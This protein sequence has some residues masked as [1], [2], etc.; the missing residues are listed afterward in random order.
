MKPAILLVAFGSASPSAWRVYAA[1]E[2]EVR[3]A[4]PGQTVQWAWTARS[5]VAR[6]RAQGETAQTMDEALATLA[7]GGFQS[8]AVL[9]LHLVPGEKHREILAASAP[10]LRL[11]YGRALLEEPEDLDEVA[12]DLAA[13]LP[14]DRPVLVVAHG[15]AHQ[16]RFNAELEALGARLAAIRPDLLLT[17]LEGE[18]APSALEAF[19]LRARSLGKVHVA[20][21]LLVAG[22]HVASDILGA[23]PHSL[24]SRLAVPH[25]TCDSALGERA[26]VRRRFQAR[27]EAALAQLEEA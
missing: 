7:A 23:S 17:R 4:H 19:I 10:G 24:R 16:A 27:L 18:A 25:F 1:L 3:A 9:S 15:H 12:R 5:L 6:M 21:F 8:A 13:E 2:A 14:A 26:F 22:E 20:P 11:A